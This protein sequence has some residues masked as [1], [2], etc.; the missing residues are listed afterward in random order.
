MSL[1]AAIDDAVADLQAATCPRPSLVITRRAKPAR[2]LLDLDE[3]AVLRAV[4]G[5]PPRPLRRID[6]LEAVRRLHR[7]EASY[8]EIAAAIHVTQRQVHRDL[9]HLGLVGNS[10]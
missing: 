5:N 4:A 6:R 10:G 9:T 8:A 7:R 1:L 3:S 2:P